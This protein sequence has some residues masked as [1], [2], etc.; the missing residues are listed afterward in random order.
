MIR[1][2]RRRWK[3]KRYAARHRS[4]GDLTVDETVDA[5]MLWVDD[6]IDMLH[7]QDAHD[8]ENDVKSIML[9]LERELSTTTGAEALKAA[10]IAT[11]DAINEVLARTFREERERAS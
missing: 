3:L 8:R 1:R 2:L 9:S 4:G 6:V 11:V 5:M 10:L 7:R